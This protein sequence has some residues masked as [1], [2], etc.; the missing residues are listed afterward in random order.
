MTQ[1]KIYYIAMRILAV[2]VAAG[3]LFGTGWIIGLPLAGIVAR[4]ALG[5]LVVSFAMLGY[6][7][8]VDFLGD[9]KNDKRKE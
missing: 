2:S 8:F 6:V 5:G 1:D 4:L 3:V 7:A 9:K